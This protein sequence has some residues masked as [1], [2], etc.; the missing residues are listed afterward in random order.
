MTDLSLL[1]VSLTKHNAHKIAQL[2]KKYKASE[3]LNKLDEVHAEKAQAYKNLSVS[4]NGE[5]PSIWKEVKKLG[6]DAINALVFIALIFSHHE[7]IS[8]MINASER[9]GFSGKIERDLQLEGKAYTNFARIID[10]LGFAV[11]LDYP[12][13]SFNVK[14]IFEIP[15]L[16]GLTRELLKYKLKAA[17]W[18][19]STSVENEAVLLNF[20]NVFGLSATAFKKWLL[21]DTQPEQ[22]YNNLIPKDKDF[23]QEKGEGTKNKNFTFEAGHE[24]RAVE[25]ILKKA[26]SKIIVSQIHNDIQNRLYNYLCHKL[27]K[28]YV[29]TE[30]DTGNGTT[31]DVVTKHNGKTIFYEIKTSPSVRTNIRQAVPQLLEY[32]H[33]PNNKKADELIIVSHLAITHDAGLYIKYLRENYNI[34]ISYSQFDLKKDK[35]I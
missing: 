4:P 34:P 20:H 26:S 3:V 12:S 25:P 16:G 5:I 7:L 21:T 32:A 23:F 35:L 29:G 8:A 33:W 17:K 14:S 11:K 6:D 1:K 27:G 18:N 22:A 24:E 2:L 28:K 9:E 15:G 30:L 31:I 13:V 10:Q 19:S